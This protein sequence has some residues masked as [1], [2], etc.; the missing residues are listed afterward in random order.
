M[1]QP[2]EYSRSEAV[3]LRRL[4]HKRSYTFYF[5]H[6]NICSWSPK[7]LHKKSKVQKSEATMLC[8]SPSPCRSHCS[9]QSQMS[10]LWAILTWALTCEWE[11]SRH[12]TSVFWN[13]LCPLSLPS[14]GFRYCSSDTSYLCC[15]LNLWPTESERMI[16]W[17]LF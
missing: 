1:L 5:V 8:R 14:W 2:I 12:P 4:G 6:G 10:S 17:L 13:T 15:V 7:S 16:K 3:C 11:V 9:W